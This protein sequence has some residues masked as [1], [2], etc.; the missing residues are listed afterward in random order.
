[1]KNLGITKVVRKNKTR[2]EKTTPQGL[3]AVEYNENLF[4]PS[5]AFIKSWRALKLL[6]EEELFD[7]KEFEIEELTS[8]E[9]KIAPITDDSKDIFIASIMCK[10]TLVAGRRADFANANFHAPDTIVAATELYKQ[11]AAYF[12]GKNAQ[13]DFFEKEN[14]A[15]E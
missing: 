14:Q 1:M 15:E 8:V 3:I 6:M 5:P 2:I 12:D 10:G 9:F 7:D 13:M 4:P 11:A